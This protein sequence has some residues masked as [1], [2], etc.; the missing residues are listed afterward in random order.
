MELLEYWVV[1]F[2]VGEMGFEVSV[3]VGGPQCSLNYFLHY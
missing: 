1:M 3:T 2:E